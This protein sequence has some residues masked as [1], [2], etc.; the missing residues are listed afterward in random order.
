MS[1]TSY[2]SAIAGSILTAAFWN[3]QVKNNGIV[4]KT[5]IADDGSTWFGALGGYSESYQAVSPGAGVVTFDLAAGNHV[6]VNVT[7]NITSFT[8]TDSVGSLTSG[9]VYP[10]VFYLKN[11]G[12]L[13]TITWTINGNTVLFSSGSTP[14]LTGTNNKHDRVVLYYMVGLGVFGDQIGINS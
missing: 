10:I 1:F 6:V 5:S 4:L 14:T 2:A 13:R 11:D 8:M 3:A 9:R 12:T 7:A